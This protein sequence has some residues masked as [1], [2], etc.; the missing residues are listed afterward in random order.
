MMHVS[1]I[2]GN[3][4]SSEKE[5]SSFPVSYAKNLEGTQEPFEEIGSYAIRRESPVSLLPDELLSF[6]DGK[7]QLAHVANRKRTAIPNLG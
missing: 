5:T 6:Q 3:D 4:N 1:I 2:Q 7:P